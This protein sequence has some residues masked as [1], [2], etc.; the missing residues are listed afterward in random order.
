[1]SWFAWVLLLAL[2][3]CAGTTW[4]AVA[5]EDRELERMFKPTY[6]VV[7]LVLAWLLQ[8]ADSTSAAGAGV[9][10]PVM[11][12]LTLSLVGDIALLPAGPVGEP[13]DPVRE[14][15]RFQVGLAAFLLAHLAYAVS[16]VRS[17]L[18]GSPF[19]WP[20]VAAPVLA[21]LVHQR[22][23]RRIVRA[24]G[25]L[26]PAV[27]AYESV[28]LGAWAVSLAVG[29][30]LLVVGTTAFVASDLILAWGRFVHAARYGRVAVM[31]TYH[32][33]QVLIVWALLA[34]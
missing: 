1:M 2:A 24:A 33:A 19:P 17:G 6:L 16:Y 34:R 20:V 9:A 8:L 29:P 22:W 18:S 11:A 15:R 14:G 4:Y 3:G 13:P 23:G 10:V 27:L 28:I 7:L 21:G 31:V 26:R 5:T 25:S 12:A 30:W 32:C